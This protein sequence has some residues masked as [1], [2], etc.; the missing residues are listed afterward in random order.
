MNIKGWHIGLGLA[1]VLI[2]WIGGSYNSLVGL[3]V[4]VDTQWAQ[5][6]TDYQRR[7]DLIPNLVATVEGVADF[8]RDTYTAVTEARTKWLNAQGGSRSEQVTAASGFDSALSR[9]LVTVENYPQLKANENFLTLQSQ[10]EGTENRVAVSRKDYNKAVGILNVQIRRFPS[11]LVAG[12]FG[13]EKGDLFESDEGANKA[14]VVD[15]SN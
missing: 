8:E 7:V 3:D 6:Q 10:L 11:N 4:N 1:V 14:P 9:L 12:L 5:V 13:F 2:I 15:F